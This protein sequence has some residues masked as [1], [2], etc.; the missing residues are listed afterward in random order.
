M[1]VTHARNAT[2]LVNIINLPPRVP[3]AGLGPNR[4]QT[5]VSD[6]QQSPAI[7]Q[8]FSMLSSKKP[9]SAQTKHNPVTDLWRVANFESGGSQFRTG[10][11]SDA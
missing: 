3:S 7:W 8:Y 2:T 10:R 5:A 11:H 1:N 4:D 9:G 6:Y